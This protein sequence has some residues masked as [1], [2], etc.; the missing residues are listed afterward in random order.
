MDEEVLIG[1]VR[2]I[3]F[4][5]NNIGNIYEVEPASDFNNLNYVIILTGEEL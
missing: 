4:N 5:S 2:T 1:K 3:H